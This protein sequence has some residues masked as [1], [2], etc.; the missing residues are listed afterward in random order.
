MQ[1]FINNE[2]LVISMEIRSFSKSTLSHKLWQEVKG[3]IFLKQDFMPSC[4]YHTGFFLCKN[5]WYCSYFG[6]K[7]PHNE[8]KRRLV[9][10]VHHVRTLL[11]L[12][13]I[14]KPLFAPFMAKLSSYHRNSLFSSQNRETLLDYFLFFL[15]SIAIV[16]G[17]GVGDW[18]VKMPHLLQQ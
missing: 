7:L 10:V 11:N 16:G 1:W 14:V 3:F 17:L 9:V 4:L 15:N 18:S 8:V 12:P 5:S 6:W 2:V 13:A